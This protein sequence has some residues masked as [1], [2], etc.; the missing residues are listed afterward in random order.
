MSNRITFKNATLMWRN[1]RGQGTDFNPAGNRNFAVLITDP[2]EAE[3]LTDE[4][5]N[6]K[7]LK[8]RDDDDTP[9]WALKVKVKFGVRPPKVYLVTYPNGEIK[10]TMLDEE[11]IGMLDWAE[12]QKVD[13]VVSAYDWTMHGKDGRTAYLDVMYFTPIEDELSGDYE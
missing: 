13:L 2:A 6:L 3:R 8:P 1:F 10:K 5:W 11:T 4:G 9:A 12:V 7:Q